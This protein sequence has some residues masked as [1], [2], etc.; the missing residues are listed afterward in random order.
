MSKR[1]KNVELTELTPEQNKLANKWDYKRHFIGIKHWQQMMLEVRKDEN[2][3]DRIIYG[4]Q[5]GYDKFNTPI[6]EEFVD[7][8][9]KVP[10]WMVLVHEFLRLE[11]Q[12][13]Y[14]DVKAGIDPGDYIFYGKY[15]TIRSYILECVAPKYKESLNRIL[16]D[17]FIRN[18]IRRAAES[19]F[20]IVEYDYDV[21]F[22]NQKQMIE[23]GR[24]FRSIKV[25]HDKIVELSEFNL[26]PNY[27]L[28][29]SS[30]WGRYHR[31]SREHKWM[32]KRIISSLNKLNEELKVKEKKAAF[33]KKLAALNLKL[34]NAFDILKVFVIT[35]QADQFVPYA[36]VHDNLT[37][38]KSKKKV[39]TN[40]P[41]DGDYLPNDDYYLTEED[42][43]MMNSI[44]PSFA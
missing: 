9:F 29:D 4:K 42:I 10:L 44:F 37:A 26:D 16:T 23:D 36:S 19:G 38:L 2:G 32:K 12:K 20:L 43:A 33:R 5:I 34:K 7:I 17:S 31:C 6:Y 13:R 14:K 30:N 25:N 11:L 40:S 22:H 21:N 39:V 27:K 24:N 8:H 15:D 28:K 3:K 35:K 41:P 18:S 1:S